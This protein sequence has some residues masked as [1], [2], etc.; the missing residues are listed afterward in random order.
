MVLAL[1]TLLSAN[2]IYLFSITWLEHFTGRVFQDFF[3]Q[4]MFL[5]HLVLGLLIILPV[6]IFGV[7][8]LLA[9]RNRRNRRAVRIGYA[10]FFIAIAVLVSGLLLTRPLGI[11]LR[12][13]SARAVVYWAHIASPLLAVWL[14]W[15][16]RLVGPRIKWYVARR[17]GIATVAVVGVMVV[18]Q[19]QDPRA[20]NVAGPRE[21][22]KYFQPSWREPPRASSFRRKP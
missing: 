7:M 18:V 14:Y 11:E 3:Y 4:I 15:L 9:A 1:F 10:L 2:G 13:P 5:V 6:I 8:H 12:A 16:H 17:L 22:D 20:W 19:M 21:G